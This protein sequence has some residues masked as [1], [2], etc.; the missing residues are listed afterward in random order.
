MSATKTIWW[1]KNNDRHEG[2]I[3]DGK[4]YTDEAATTRVPIGAT[5]QTEGGTFK[6][7]SSG[8]I[9]TYATAKN[10]YETKGNA[11]INA[12]EAAGK[13]QQERINSAT[14]AAIAALNNQKQTIEENRKDADR[15]AREAYLKA[16]NPFGALEEQRVRLGLDESG[17]A[18][19][20]KLKLASAYATQLNENLR[21]MNE[22]LRN[23]DVQIAEAR[24]SGQYE[25]ASIYE[26]RAQ[27]VMQQQLAL[28]GS[29]FS[30]DM[31][32]MGQAES[33]R[34]FDEQMAENTR[35]FDTQ[36]E[37]QR[38]QMAA[39]QAQREA[40]NKY[41]LALTFIENGKNASFISE[42]L[43]IPQADVNTLIAAVNAQKTARSSGS[44]GGS[45]GGKKVDDVLSRMLSYEDDNMARAYLL[46][47]NK[48]DE[49][50]RAEMMELYEEAKTATEGADG[51]GSGFNSVY[52]SLRNVEN[53]G[54]GREKAM[55][56]LQQG[57]DAGT[58]TNAGYAKLK[59][60]FK[61][62]LGI[63]G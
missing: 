57:L 60:Y 48:Y 42:T 43:G 18:E 47:L 45:G 34:Q 53:K 1:D 40:D 31:S 29:I 6:M 49:A 24:A 9:P 2:W 32:A 11:A 56:I 25:L 7:T 12:Y 17:Y 38:E 30:G 3:K 14:N 51:L 8:G 58:L 63:K 41:N 16:A 27:N 55:E 37:L 20:S 23:L 5:V 26:A 44:G 33:T 4:T 28:Q 46:S 39:A 19:S 22:Q 50:E 54:L 36:T 35:Q 10:Q 21:A 15:A 59:G 52:A 61:N 62:L 13:V